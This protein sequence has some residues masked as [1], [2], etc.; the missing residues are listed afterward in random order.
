MN[1]HF[2]I[3]P[4]RPEEAGL[5]LEFIKKLAVYEKYADEVAAD[6]AILRHSLFVERAASATPR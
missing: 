6:E 2:N 3:R 4:A 5:V 1:N